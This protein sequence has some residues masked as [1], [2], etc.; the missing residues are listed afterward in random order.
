ML[1][2][3]GVTVEHRL[4]QRKVA[5][6]MCW[7]TFRALLTLCSDEGLTLKTSANT[8][9]TAFSI[10]TATFRW[11]SLCFDNMSQ[12]RKNKNKTKTKQNNTWKIAEIIVF[13]VP[14]SIV[15]LVTNRFYLTLLLPEFDWTKK[16]SKSWTIQRNLKVW[17]LKWKLSMSTF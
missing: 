4:Y 1:L 7:L 11:N 13:F 5:G 3:V 8:F 2:C 6:D 12:K 14:V 17:P 16:T 10:S 9:S 15:I